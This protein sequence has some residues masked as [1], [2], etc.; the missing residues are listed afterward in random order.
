MIMNINDHTYTSS[1]VINI[2]LLSARLNKWISLWFA[3]R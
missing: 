3:A 2:V 1:Q